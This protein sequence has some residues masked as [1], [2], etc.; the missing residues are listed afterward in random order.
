M[1][2]KEAGLTSFPYVVYRILN[3]NRINFRKKHRKKMLGTERRYAKK[4]QRNLDK[5]ESGNRQF[6][7]LPPCACCL[8]ARGTTHSVACIT[9]PFTD[10]R[11]SV[12]PVI[13]TKSG[14]ET[15][16]QLRICQGE[17]YIDDE[18]S[19]LLLERLLLLQ[20]W[21]KFNAVLILNWLLKL[22]NKT[23]V[24]PTVHIEKVCVIPYK[25]HYTGVVLTQNQ[26]N[27]N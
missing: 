24:Y 8:G 22:N 2:V 10:S 26:P 19:K 12:W 23:T 17:I 11:A 4:F 7:Q 25:Y 27:R 9:T 18:F 21:P 13:T 1:G 14:N 15:K 20:H 16:A 3:K 6:D 5:L